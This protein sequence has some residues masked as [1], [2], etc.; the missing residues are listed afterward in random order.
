GVA[1]TLDC[2]SR[3]CK[4]DPRLGAAHAVT[5]AFRN[6]TAVGARAIG[7]SD[8]LNFGSPEKPEGMW[9]IAEGIRGL[10]DASRAFEVPIVSGNV[11]LYN[12]SIDSAILPT[13]LVA[14]VGLIDDA[15]KAVKAQFQNVGDKVLAIGATN[16]QELGGSLYLAEHAKVEKGAL[17]LLN[18]Q[19]EQRTAE[20]VR[21][22]IADSLLHSCHDVSD[23]GL[24]VAL[25]E[26]CFTPYGSPLG[27]TLKAEQPVR[28]KEGFLF[29]ETG[30]RYVISF[31]PENEEAIRTR[32]VNAK[33]GISG[34]G[35]VGGQSI[36]IDKVVSLDL[37]KSYDKWSQGLAIFFG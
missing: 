21:L 27:V 18:Y 5:E 33:L 3:Y 19:L 4:I 28:S 34:S 24:L 2:N 36:T 17:P 10:G 9:E 8:C 16:E 37:Q 14:M 13:P 23:G 30:A 12:E 32:I 1:M 11:S 15:S 31:S 35:E 6:V 20:L 26:S 25:A 7:I 22:L 29:A